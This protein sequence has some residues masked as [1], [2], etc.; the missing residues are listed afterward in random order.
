MGIVYT[1]IRL[2]NGA[3]PE[4][5]Q[6]S[7]TAVADKG[8]IDLVIPEH[9][10]IQL[11]LSELT[12]RE[13]RMA[14]G[15]RRLVRYAG[16]IKIEM[17]GRDCFTSAAIMGDQ[18]LLGAVPMEQM[19]LVVDPRIQRVVPNPENPNVPKFIAYRA[20]R[21]SSVATTSDF[22]TSPRTMA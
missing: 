21:A 4:L 7:V 17:A 2:S 13:L 15:G 11:Q 3:K 12:P 19:D 14:D 9:L 5:E 10:A 8:A 22:A 6:I 1:E 20:C 16:P 18:V